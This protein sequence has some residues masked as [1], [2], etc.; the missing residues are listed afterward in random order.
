MK[1]LLPVLFSFF[2]LTACLETIPE[3]VAHG[4]WTCVAMEGQGTPEKIDLS[5][6]KFSFNPDKTYTYVSQNN[7]KEKG[8]F[9][10]EGTTLYTHGE[11][12]S[13]KGVII[14]EYVQDT[15]VLEMNMG[16]MKQI[17]TLARD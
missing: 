1:Y 13:P 15:L 5:T 16:G 8:T 17:W 14:K 3:E 6:V 2:F 4:N 10:T 11:G 9:F 12:M 7:Y